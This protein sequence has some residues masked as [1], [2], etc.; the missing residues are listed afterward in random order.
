MSA[1]ELTDRYRAAG[2]P[3]LALVNGFVAF[4]VAVVVA[5]QTPATGYELGIYRA[6]PLSFWL[7]VAV[8]SGTALLV[9]FAPTSRRVRFAAWLLVGLTVAA[10]V[11]LPILRGYHFYG[12]GD[13]LSHLGFALTYVSG[14]DSPLSLLHPGVHL[15]SIFV[16]GVTGTALP[17][18]FMFVVVG[19]SLVFVVFVAL[20]VRVM[21]GDEWGITVGLFSAALVLPINNV[22]VH[23]HMHPTS[24][25]ILFLP[26]LLYLVVK[27]VRLPARSGLDRAVTPLGAVLAVASA[28]MLFFHPQQALN[29]LLLFGTVAGLQFLAR[30]W[31]PDHA[32]ASHRTLYGQTALLGVLFALWAPR[33]DRFTGAVQSVGQSLLTGATPADEIAQRSGSLSSLGGGIEELLFKLFF[34]S[35]VFA[36]VAGVFGLASL[37]GRFDRELPAENAAIKYLTLG[38]VPVFGGFL[39]FFVT[40]QTTQHF[41]YVGF[42]MA[43]ATV[44]TGVALTHFATRSTFR[45]P[46]LESLSLGVRIALVVLFA[47]L[48]PLSTLALHPSPYIYQDSSHVTAAKMD[49]YE[50]AFRIRDPDVPF[51]GVR[52]GPRRYVDAI[53]GTGTPAAEEFPGKRDS[54]PADVFASA[55]YADYFEGEG[56]RYLELTSTEVIREVRLWDGFRYPQRGF[57]AL[58]ATP[59]IDRVQSNG[60]VQLYLI[61]S[62]DDDGTA[63]EAGD[64]T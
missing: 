32:F 7:G 12:A 25:A 16:A 1:R 47:V 5:H 50:T 63:S 10:L 22:S 48:L 15:A 30:R 8:A 18:A 39:L 36:G 62:S 14:A 23:P 54:V 58:D 11:A 29:V 24:Q 9:A 17:W 61:R 2:W 34:V 21:S 45:Q 51:T 13:S 56:R 52:A 20:C 6:T 37:L 33:S 60:E 57:D 44:L 42:L 26:V 46:S 28:G 27:Y 38:L 59:G 4:T 53:Y 40:S 49:G 31:R 41:R 19:F 55:S 43:G 35:L 64:D 3:K